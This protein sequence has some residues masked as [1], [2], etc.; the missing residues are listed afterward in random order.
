MIGKDP[1][2]VAPLAETAE[3]EAIPKAE[4]P[5]AP[6]SEKELSTKISTETVCPAGIV[7]IGLKTK[8]ASSLEFNF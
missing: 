3:A 6:G 8:V 5:V 1:E 2:T 7:S 4:F